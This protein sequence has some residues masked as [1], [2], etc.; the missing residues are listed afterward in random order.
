MA[1]LIERERECRQI[2]AAVAAAVG[3]DGSVI[4]L[5]GEAG[6]GKTSLLAHGSLCGVDAGMRVLRARGGELERAYP[7]GIVRQLFEALV[8][9]AQPEDRE[10][11][12]TG[13]AGIGAKLLAA[14]SMSDGGE[15]DPSSF[16]HGLYW[17]SA[18]L[19]VAQPLLIAIDDAQWADDASI[20]F[21]SY[22]A[23]RVGE[24]A[25]LIVYASRVGEGASELLPAVMEPALVRTVLRP[26]ALTRAGSAQLIARLMTRAGSAPFARACHVATNGNPFLLEELLRALGAEDTTPADERVG[27]IVPRTV[28]RATLARLRLLGPDATRLALAIAIF[29][30]AAELRHAAALAGLTPDVA[31][32]AADALTAACVV[33]QGRPLEFI[34]PLVRTA[35]YSEL[36]EGQR[37]ASH[38]RAAQ[39]L[40]LEGAEDVAIAPHL[41]ASETTGDLWVV[42]SLLAAAQAVLERGAPDAACTYLERALREPPPPALRRMLLLKLG[43]AELTLARPT[44]VGHLREVLD[45][46]CDA[47]ACFDAA[48]N[49]MWALAYRNRI[50]DAVQVGIDALSG[51]VGQHRELTLRLE[52]E[53]FFIAQFAPACAKPALQRLT[54]Y[55]S[56]LNAETAGERLLL[57]CRAFGATHTSDS[58]AAATAELARAALADGALLQDRRAR[59][60]GIFMA[61]WAL[62]ESDRLGEAERYLD[63]TIEQARQRGS[64]GTFASR[65]ACRCMILIRQ[66]RLAE[67]EAEALGL[68]AENDPHA[69]ARPMLLA[70]LL[71]TMR[72]RAAPTTW[73]GTLSQHGIDGDLSDM[74]LAGMLLL[75]RGRLRLAAGDPHAAL[76]DFEQARSLEALAGIDPGAGTSRASCALAHA[77]IGDLAAAQALA[78][79][80]VQRARQWDTP[81]AVASALRTAGLVARNDEQ[82]DLL[83]ESV[84][85]VEQAPARYEQ[86]QSL[87]AYGAALRRTGHRRD[88]RAPLTHALDLA[89]RCGASALARAAREELVASGAR[90]RRDVR[91]GPDALTPSEWRVARLVADGLTN[92]EAAQAL[93]VTMRTIEGHLTHA[94]AK[95]DINSRRELEQAMR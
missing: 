42:E 60:P 63:I 76:R 28:A 13:A 89:T 45:V 77:R 4:A 9:T 88:S 48:Q 24:L 71:T 46:T 93:F 49:L 65:A 85:A 50:D 78:R 20:A 87:A 91:T 8:A 6:I 84:T 1:L 53:M 67:A 51:P 31:G 21:L 11:W 35:V 69:I 56:T 66:G 33:R 61:V 2:E 47:E 26:A 79:D 10:R 80:A 44:A 70:S 73:D 92:R 7:Y 32:L 64:T 29:G 40:L 54:R 74:A 57:A 39:L 18:N 5:E 12:L 19:S 75:A 17:L 95:L 22:L 59:S 3:G 15:L 30:K 82:I 86:A 62:L 34:H 25:I 58:S 55:A 68:L 37:A 43:A 16:L 14:S 52:G 27:Q 23:R 81:S 90:P 83:R 36:A 41:L 38:K 72:E 94:Y